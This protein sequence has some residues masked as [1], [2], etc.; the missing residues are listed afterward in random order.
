M[1]TLQDGVTPHPDVVS[2]ELKEAVD[3]SMQ[4]LLKRAKQRPKL[5]NPLLYLSQKL[6]QYSDTKRN[7]MQSGEPQ[8]IKGILGERS[9]RRG[10]VFESDGVEKAVPKEDIS[11]LPAVSEKTSDNAEAASKSE[12]KKE[13]Q[14]KEKKKEE[15]VPKDV[16]AAQKANLKPTEK[17]VLTAGNTEESATIDETIF[18]KHLLFKDLS[19]KTVTKLLEAMVDKTYKKG[20][21]VCR[22]NT[23][24]NFAFVL[25]SGEFENPLPKNEFVGTANLMY[26]IKATTTMIVSSDT[27]T[28]KLL[29]RSKFKSTMIENGKNQLKEYNTLIK[30][31]TFFQTLEHAEVKQLVKG[32]RTAKYGAEDIIFQVCESMAEDLYILK[33]GTV[34]LVDH[35][36]SKML[37]KG[38]VFGDEV[39][40]SPYFPY[41]RRTTAISKSADTEVLVINYKSFNR[42]LG[43]MQTFIRRDANMYKIYQEEIDPTPIVAVNGRRDRR[44]QVYDFDTTF[45]EIEDTGSSPK[46]KPKK[47]EERVELEKEARKIM[48]QNDYFSLN[49]DN[50]Q[51]SQVVQAMV[52]EEFEAGGEIVKE[53]EMSNKLYLVVDG[54]VVG[55]NSTD[56][57]VEEPLLFGKNNMVKDCPWSKTLISPDDSED[58]TTCL[59]ITR[60]NFKRAIKLAIVKR[61]SEIMKSLKIKVLKVLT[62]KELLKLCDFVESKVFNADTVVMEQGDITNDMYVIVQ[63][64][65]EST[66]KDGKSRTL[67][68]GDYFAEMALMGQIP[69]S[70]TYKTKKK[71]KLFVINRD[72]FVRMLGPLRI[73]ITRS[74]RL[75]AEFDRRYR[76][77]R[78]KK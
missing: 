55:K 43:S 65:I 59:S 5:T 1:E 42:L 78:N 53:G 45:P 54:D 20:E 44:E 56:E 60:E 28:I 33:S 29:Q 41:S 4:E 17:D 23:D 10:I 49:Y 25:T 12:E 50:S 51:I 18:Q 34:E 57:D 16:K 63:G 39:L 75:Y 47:S 48:K 27:L 21:V 36:E 9:G 70:L 77:S 76:G 37:S 22:A 38:D 30:N 73:L 66:K 69:S 35:N 24:C 3:W 74:P 72:S 40:T 32:L 46:R 61:N 11:N 19:K 68:K 15:S 62:N 13:E 6:Q 64:E 7:T 31:S 67:K 26:A 8:A 52:E 2:D 58:G 71:T 14:S